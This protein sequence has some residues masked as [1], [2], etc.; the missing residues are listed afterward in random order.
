MEHIYSKAT[1]KM[2]E[3]DTCIE[4]EHPEASPVPTMKS[5]Q[6]QKKNDTDMTWG[7]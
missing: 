6:E 3:F 7:G 1:N 2:W 5:T 4:N